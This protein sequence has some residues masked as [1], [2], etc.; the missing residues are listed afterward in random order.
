MPIYSFMTQDG[1]SVQKVF[2]PSNVPEE[3]K[4]QN[5]KI[6][7]RQLT[8]CAFAYVVNDNDQ[9]DQKKREEQQR[10]YMKQYNVQAFNGLKGQSKQQSRKDFQL[11]KNKLSQQMLQRKQKRAKKTNRKNWQK[12]ELLI[13]L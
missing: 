5:G 12:K 2:S 8:T 13:R 11:L 4:L 3:I 9:L 10:Q 7:K 1:E 6:A